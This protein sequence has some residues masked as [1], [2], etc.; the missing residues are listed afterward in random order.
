MDPV[1]ADARA[2]ADAVEEA[3]SKVALAD[4]IRKAL[5]DGVITKEQAEILWATDVEKLQVKEAAARFG[6]TDGAARVRVHRERANLRSL[7]SGEAA[8]QR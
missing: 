7:I 3:T 2:A 6:I 5:T 1:F 8:G 4:L